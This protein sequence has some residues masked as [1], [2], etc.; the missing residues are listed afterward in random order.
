MT[1]FVLV[2]DDVRLKLTCRQ[3]FNVDSADHALEMDNVRHTIKTNTS[4]WSAQI[5]VTGVTLHLLEW[6]SIT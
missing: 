4:S 2:T 5:T 6:S 1:V 3:V